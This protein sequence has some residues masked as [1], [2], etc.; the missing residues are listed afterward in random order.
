MTLVNSALAVT[1]GSWPEVAATVKATVANAVEIVAAIRTLWFA[2]CEIL[3][4]H[5]EMPGF[6]YYLTTHET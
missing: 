3:L 2:R 6:E 1:D 4:T 5:Q